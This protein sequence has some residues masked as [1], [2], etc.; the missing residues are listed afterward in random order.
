MSGGDDS[1]G[2][3]EASQER[4]RARAILI[5][6]P[7]EAPPTAPTC[8]PRPVRLGVVSMTK[9]PANFETWLAHHAHHVGA[10]RFY[11][12]VEDSQELEQLLLHHQPWRDLVRAREA[13][14]G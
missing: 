9:R 3:I 6:A 14:A 7:P 2:E 11:L 10:E 13:I 4:A 5:D 8:H 1:D 12:R